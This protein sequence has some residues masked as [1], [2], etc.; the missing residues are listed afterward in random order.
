[1]E[2]RQQQ[3]DGADLLT[4][5]ETAQKLGVSQHTLAVWRSSGRYSLRFVKI[6]GCVRY[7]YSDILEF[8]ESRVVRHTG[9][10]RGAA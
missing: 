1:M 9:E 4:A 8:I 5:S 10:L 2:N 6:G 3:F 7:R